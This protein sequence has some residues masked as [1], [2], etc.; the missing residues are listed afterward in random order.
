[1]PCFCT[2]TAMNPHARTL[3]LLLIAALAAAALPAC[4]SGPPGPGG[5]RKG[6]ILDA[7]RDRATSFDAMVEDLATVPMVFVG[8]S[9]PSAEHHE[10]QRRIVDELSRRNPH[11][12]VG[13]EMLQRP[14]QEV[15]DRWSAGTMSEDGFLREVSWFDQWADWD[16]Y[17]PILRLCRDRHLRV[18]GLHLPALGPGG[19]ISR[20]VSREGL[21]NIPP[22]MRA[23][24]PEVIDT[25]N[26]AHRESIRR[27]FFAHP[28]ME[29]MEGMEERFDRFYQSQCTWD[30]TMAESA[31]DALRASPHPGAA[32]V[33]LAG[34]MHVVDFHSIPERARRRNGLDFRVVLPL[35]VPGRDEE[36]VA[37]GPDRP[38]DYVLFT[39]PT[40]NPDPAR[41]GVGIRG[42]DNLVTMVAPTG[43][44]AEA[45]LAKGDLLTGID[46]FLVR[47]L[48]DVKVALD[49]RAPGDV[50]R[51]RW[52]RDG[53]AMEGKGVIAAAP[54]M[55]GPVRAPAKPEG[56]TKEAGGGAGE[57]PPK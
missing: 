40:P 48:V 51:L 18:V 38:A 26:A 55:M 12:I 4:A 33:V 36:P 29:K 28:G 32:I 45:G 22:W 31:V 20:A 9:H 10:I 47:D 49:G 50:V 5:P 11:L 34:S 14:Y 42:G 56:G 41:L 23:Q 7:R 1:M 52:T 46:D 25:T 30:E 19:V 3:P 2:V 44:A 57:A 8:E 54:S 37:V 27:I 17:A 53:A 43:A 21:D 39:G 24:L 15:L 13:L 16:L 35:E 6:E